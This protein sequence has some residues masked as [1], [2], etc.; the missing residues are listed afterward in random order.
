MAKSRPRTNGGKVFPTLSV[1]PILGS[2][3]MHLSGRCPGIW[4]GGTTS[5]DFLFL[6]LPLAE[7]IPGEQPGGDQRPLLHAACPDPEADQWCEGAAGVAALRDG[8]AEPRVPDPVGCEVMA[9]AGD[10]HLPPPAGGRGC[11]VSA[12]TPCPAPQTL[13]PHLCPP[14]TSHCSASSRPQPLFPAQGNNS[15]FR[16]K[17]PEGPHHSRAPAL[18]PRALLTS[19][20]SPQSSP[21]PHHPPLTARPSSSSR[22]RAHPDSARTRA[23]SPERSLPEPP[24]HLPAWPPEGLGPAPAPPVQPPAPSISSPMVVG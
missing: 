18:P 3:S 13:Q 17:A 14:E 24:A 19:S 8:A 15:S 16:G 23:P 9:G 21:P 4:G 1:W 2:A 6:S 7:S 12:W 20:L 5:V 10:R 22:S 11:P